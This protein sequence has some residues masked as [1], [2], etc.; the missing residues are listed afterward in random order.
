MREILTFIG[1]VLVL[2]LSAALIGPQFVDWDAERDVMAAHL[3]QWLG[4]PVS[5]SGPVSL[6]L[7]PAPKLRL[8]ALAI[9]GSAGQSTVSARDVKLDLAVMPLLQGR[10]E[11]TK[12]S[13]DHVQLKLVQDAAGSFNLPIPATNRLK[14]VAL[15]ALQMRDGVVFLV[16]PDGT[17]LLTL[18]HLDVSAQAASLLGPFTAS[19]S[20]ASPQGPLHFDLST[21]NATQ[22]ALRLTWSSAAVG[23]LPQAHFDGVMTLAPSAPQLEGQL[24]LRG[25]LQ[26]APA[27]MALPW[28]SEG[29]VTADLTHLSA[30][31]LKLVLG[32]AARTVRA[33]GSASLHF[34]ALPHGTISLAAPQIDLDQMI[35]A[36]PGRLDSS[37]PV[38]KLD[39]VSWLSGAGP[40]ENVS[41]PV[42][43]AL[44]TPLI[45]WGGDTLRHVS[46]QVDVDPSRPLHLQLALRAPAGTQVAMQGVADLGSAARFTG[47]VAASTDDAPA[48]SRWLGGLDISAATALVQALKSQ[49]FEQLGW[50]GPLEVSRVSF[51]SQKAAIRLDRTRLAG[52]IAYTAASKAGA[53]RLFA[54]LDAP[55]L[56]I[57]HVPQGTAL[58]DPALDL[59]VALRAHA[60][61]VAH[62][63]QGM[64]DAGNLS[65]HLKRTNGRMDV[66]SLKLSNLGGA[67][68]TASGILA[69]KGGSIAADISASRL[70]EA[71][72]LVARLFP[73]R[74]SAAL[75]ARA[76]FLAPARLHITANSATGADNDASPPVTA[77]IT[78]SLAGT[79]ISGTITPAADGLKAHIALE[80]DEAASFLQQVGLATLP[81]RGLGG[82]A[83]TLEASGIAPHY[84]VTAK[85]VV[86]G[87]NFDA[88][89]EVHV[90]KMHV[91]AQGHVHGASA[92]LLPLTRALALALPASGLHLP[93]T[94]QADFTRDASGLAVTGLE[95]EA[96]GNGFS[97]ALQGPA[98]ASQN[99]GVTGT[100]KLDS[101]TLPHLLSLVLGTPATRDPAHWSVQV[102]EPAPGLPKLR[103]L[104]LEA[105]HFVTGLA[106]DVGGPASFDLTLQH[107]SLNIDHFNGLVAGG[108]VAAS[109]TLA[110]NGLEAS[111]SGAGTF[112]GIKLNEPTLQSLADGRLQVVATGK[113]PAKLVANLA[114]QGTVLLHQPVVPRAD[115]AALGQLLQGLGEGTGHFDAAHVSAVLN[116]ALDQGPLHMADQNMIA[117]LSSGVLQLDGTGR[118]EALHLSLDVNRGTLKQSLRLPA[119]PAP[120]LWS[121][122]PPHIGVTFEGPLARPQRHIVMGALLDGLATRA[123]A[124]QKAKIAAFKADVQERAMLV[125]RLHGWQKLERDAAAEKQFEANRTAAAAAAQ[126]AQQAAAAQKALRAAQK[127]MMQPAPPLRT[128]IIKPLPPIHL[129]GA[130]ASPP[131]APLNLTPPSSPVPPP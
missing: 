12:A 40:Q 18:H 80:S 121:G 32:E 6:R 27:G 76:P 77:E 47:Q 14:G 107:Q 56:D 99:L 39:P 29:M 63:G 55:A 22:G 46:A 48:L 68:L 79:K 70:V 45:N 57:D 66:R 35:A 75:Q 23:I 106:R 33:T 60:V 44:S 115:G 24:Q 124:V 49:P 43:L 13:F 130:P 97:G 10:F 98:S 72:A 86:A 16:K 31:K 78:G 30:S 95:G 53:A 26:A 3:T 28:R 122:P 118:P 91:D 67:D 62:F 51:A 50:Q 111:L 7:L 15:K 96:D 59:D 82:A 17:P 113:S 84:H 2:V 73:G 20:V 100:L 5:L 126:K 127:I 117:T 9:G 19:G 34:G 81:L 104:H 109:L 54:D 1:L 90:G 58:L 42:T 116:T 112:T 129:Q 4:R 61:R 87:T 92:D 11:L 94:V 119:S 25:A 69:A 37:L 102:F 41:F 88:S 103:G 71:S 123:I 120:P 74:L 65:F 131:K 64:I 36:K 85:G 125:R 105:R 110:R 8:G 93:F 38:V 114:G 52:A 128:I 108:K 89:A 21:G 83:V 101:L